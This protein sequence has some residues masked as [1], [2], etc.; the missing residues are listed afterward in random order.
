M[1]QIVRSPERFMERKIGQPNLRWELLVLLAVGAIGA[2]GSAYVGLEVVGATNDDAVNLPVAGKVIEPVVGVFVLWVA[3]A[4]SLH[5]IGNALGGRGPARQLLKTVPWAL[6]PVGIGNL[7]RTGA[8][9]LV[10]QGIDVAAAMSESRLA[11]VEGA[12]GAGTGESLYVLATVLLILTALWSGYLMLLAVQQAK[13]LTREQAVRAVAVP[14]AVHV[15]V[16]VRE[17]LAGV[18]VL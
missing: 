14:V 4:V 5:F 2:L 8:T 18:G 7:L 17:L 16:L 10:Y 12:Y 6:I 11:P 15:L 3:Y 1:L 13:D 9:Y